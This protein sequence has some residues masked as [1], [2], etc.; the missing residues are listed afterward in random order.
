MNQPAYFIT[1]REEHRSVTYYINELTR[2]HPIN[3]LAGMRAITR[4]HSG[5]SK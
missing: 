2:E 5:V 3:W 1:Y 4:A